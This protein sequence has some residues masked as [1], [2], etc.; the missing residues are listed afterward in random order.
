M[1]WETLNDNCIFAFVPEAEPLF[2][3]FSLLSGEAV[4]HV[5]T[6]LYGAARIAEWRR[7]Y[8]FL[9]ETFYAVKALGPY[10]M[11]DFLLDYLS[12]GF[13]AEGFR[14]DILSLPDD[15]RVFRQAGWSWFGGTTQ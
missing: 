13:T 6:D 7:R 5:C 3:V 11:F 15:E 14:D 12:E 9:F 2:G 8:R 10:S 4:H 1:R